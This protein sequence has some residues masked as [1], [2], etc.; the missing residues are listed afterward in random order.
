MKILGHAYIATHATEGNEQLLIIGSLLPEMLP[1]IPNDVFGYKELHEG[2]KRLLKYL[3]TCRPDKRD[4]ALGLLS[5]GAELGADKYSRAGERFVA[6]ERQSLIRE[7][8]LAQGVSLETAESRLHNYVGL[9]IDCLLVQNEPG[10]VKKVQE[11][12]RKIDTKEIACLIA[13]AFD[14][15]KTKVMKM[16]KT[17]FKNIYCWE[18][19]TSVEGLARIWARQSSGLPEKDKVDIPRSSVVIKKC[20]SLLEKEWKGFLESISTRVRNNLQ[21][22]SL[23]KRGVV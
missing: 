10:L 9:G 14:K 20:A 21:V 23:N 1:Y 6:P 22:F 13:R 3:E 17:L 18:D 7:I 16:T 4:L 11:T 8:S 5:H 2:G 12:L 19:L 15:D